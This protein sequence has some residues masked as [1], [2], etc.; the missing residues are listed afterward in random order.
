V[1]PTS[2]SASPR[3]SEAPDELERARLG[4]EVEPRRQLVVR[5]LRVDAYVVETRLVLHAPGTTHRPA[6]TAATACM[7]LR[8]LEIVVQQ[9]PQ[10]CQMV[11]VGRARLG[12]ELL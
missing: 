7:A 6:T 11:F 2:P 9:T 8:L 12:F 10:D 1:S 5:L 3:Y 4:A